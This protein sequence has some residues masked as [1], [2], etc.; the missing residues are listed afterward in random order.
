MASPTP[1]TEGLFLVYVKSTVGVLSRQAA[2]IQIA[3]QAFPIVALPSSSLNFQGNYLYGH[4]VKSQKEKGMKG[5]TRELSWA[6]PG[7]GTLDV[8]SQFVRGPDLSHMVCP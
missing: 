4:G 2:I 7:S 3:I 6:S 5:S 1:H 8:C